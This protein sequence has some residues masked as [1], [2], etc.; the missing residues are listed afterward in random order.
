MLKI[1]ELIEQLHD[2]YNWLREPDWEEKF[3]EDNLIE[4]LRKR[5]SGKL[6]GIIS[7]LEN[8]RRQNIEKMR[9]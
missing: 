9:K 6:Y 7:E 8:L 4:W 5:P 2:V 3:N 1:D